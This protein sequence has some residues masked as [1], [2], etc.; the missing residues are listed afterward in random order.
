MRAACSRSSG[1]WLLAFLGSAVLA[2]AVAQMQRDPTRPSAVWLAAQPQAPG[3][4][5]AVEQAAPEAQIVVTGPARQF[6]MVDGQPVRVG[7]SYN[8]AKLIAIEADGLV[9][10]RNGTR[11]KFGIG[12]GIH[13]QVKRAEPPAVTPKP[14]KKAMNGEG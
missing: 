9:W 6:A 13:K 4:A 10:Q 14:K 12:A 7:Q 5:A 8:G 2:P 11:E 1:P 3:A